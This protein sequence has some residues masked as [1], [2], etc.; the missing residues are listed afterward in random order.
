MGL[1]LLPGSVR[2]QCSTMVQSVQA[3]QKQLAVILSQIGTFTNNTEQKAASWTNMRSHFQD[4]E[5]IISAINGALD[6]ITADCQSVSSLVGSETLD[7]DQLN[8]SIQYLQQCNA[9]LQGCID[10]CNSALS[11][12]NIDSNYASALRSSISHYQ[13]MINSNNAKIQEL[14]KKI[15]TLYQIEGATSKQFTSVSALFSAAVSGLQAVSLSY[16]VNSATF[17]TVSDQSWK[18]V[19]G[20]SYM[21]YLKGKMIDDQN[22]HLVF[23]EQIIMEYLKKNEKDLSEYEKRAITE[24]MAL[25]K[26]E[27]IRYESYEETGLDGMSIDE[28]Q[29]VAWLANNTDYSSFNDVSNSYKQLYVNILHGIITDPSDTSYAASIRKTVENEK[30]TRVDVLEKTGPDQWLTGDLYKYKMSAQVDTIGNR[31]KTTDSRET[32]VKLA[33]DAS[34]AAPNIFEGKQIPQYSKTQAKKHKNPEKEADWK[35]IQDEINDEFEKRGLRKTFDSKKNGYRYLHP[36]GKY[37]TPKKK[38]CKFYDEKLAVDVS[39]TAAVSRTWKE[40]GYDNGNGL[41]VNAK[42]GTAEAHA[43]VSAG[44]YKMGK[45]GQ[46]FWSPGVKAEVG[47]SATAFEGEVSKQVGSDMLG[48]TVKG[49]TTVGKAE[50]QANAGAVLFDENHKLNPQLS[51]GASAEAIGGEL[52]GKAQVD[53]LGGSVGVKGSV[54]YGI[55]AHADVGLKDG[56]V[57]VDIGATVGVGVSVGVEVDVGGMVNTVVD[58]AKAAADFIGDA[59]DSLWH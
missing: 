29:S 1:R 37:T 32:S 38:D 27:A 47:A 55:G 9:S 33:F 39:A 59:W 13:S 10:S 52:T 19:L 51:A 14:Q 48:V 17:A 15:Q 49:T 34:G 24:T 44:M 23:N 56:V 41:I 50:A 40:Y 35:K 42:V 18:A 20:E 6:Q 12:P 2:L 5:M 11:T 28:L 36:K 8:A 54:N 22:G 4:Y 26:D 21:D 45:D 53:V 57:K 30:V 31:T 25:I 58:G 16:D 46:R 7:E 3:A 43:S